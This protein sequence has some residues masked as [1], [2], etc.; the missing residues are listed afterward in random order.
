[1]SDDSKRKRGN[2]HRELLDTFEKATTTFKLCPNRIWVVAREKLPQ[3][4][5]QD[6][7]ILA[8][9]NSISN[10][11]EHHHDLCTFDFCEHSQ[12]DFTAVEQR[13]ECE[14]EE[15]NDCVQLRG[16]FSRDILNAAAEAGSS[17]VWSLDGTSIVETPRPYMAISHVW[18]D[19][20]GTGGWAEGEVN[21]CLYNLFQEIARQFQCEGIWWDTI[22][23]PREKSARNKAIRKIQNNYQDARIT[24]VHD[25]FLRNWEWVNAEGACF[26]IL[27]SPWFSRG[28]TALELAN[29][30][31]VKVVFKGPC[32]PLIKDLDEQILA[33]DDTCSGPHK[34]ATDIIR[35]LRKGVSDLNGLL[36]VLGARH[37]SWPKDIAII[38]GQ[39]VGVEIASQSGKQDIWQQDIYISILRKL[40]KVSPQHLF[41]NSATM[42]RV[43][44]CPNSLFDMPIFDSSVMAESEE[45]L[46]ITED[47]DLV[48]K[49]KCIPVNRSHMEKCVWNGIHPLIRKRLEH[50]LEDEDECVLLT[51][52]VS[53]SEIG[54]VDRAL[55]VKKLGKGSYGYVGAL[56]FHPGLTETEGR[57]EEV[58]LLADIRGRE[59]NPDSNARVTKSR[60]YSDWGIPAL[61][62]AALNGDENRVEN[63]V[64]TASPSLHELASKRIALNYA[65]WRGH[66]DVFHELA[67]SLVEKAED[68]DVQDKLGQRP[69]HLAA[70][71][72]DE[73]AVSYLLH[74]GARVEAKAED[75]EEQTALHRAAWGG[76]TPVVQLL[77]NAGSHVNTKDKFENIALHTAA[78]KGFESVATLLIENGADVDAK[79]WNHLTPLHYAVI[80]RHEAVVKLL[81]DSGAN[82]EAKDKKF[83]WTALH[84]AALTEHEAVVRLLLDNGADIEARD[85]EFGWTALHLAAVNGHKAVVEL[86][87]MRNVKINL[88]DEKDR[89]MLQIAI[90]NG[91]EEVVKLLANKDVKDNLKDEKRRWTAL[92]CA[93]MSGPSA[94]FKPLVDKVDVNFKDNGQTALQL[95]AEN[96]YKA[97]VKKLLVNM[98]YE[99]NAKD[100]DGR[101]ALRLAAE[102]GHVA[103][104]KLL[105]DKGVDADSEHNGKT[106]LHLAVANGHQAVVKLL[107]E[108]GV[109]INSTRW[110]DSAHSHYG[111]TALHWAAEGGYVAMVKLLVENGADINTKLSAQN[112]T[113]LHL[114]A[115]NGYVAVTK[116]LVENGA[117]IE[118]KRADYSQ[119]PLHLAV[120]KG[121]VAVIKQLIKYGA[122]VNVEQEYGQTALHSAAANGDVAIIELLAK[123]GADIDS[124][125]NDCKGY[126]G[127]YGDGYQP[128]Y[129]NYRGQTALHLAVANGHEA[130]VKLLVENGADINS[131]EWGCNRNS[132]HGQAAL[133][134]AAKGGHLVMV[135]LLVENGA[136]IDLENS[137]RGIEDGDGGDKDYGGRTAL[138]MAAANGH[139]A[140]VS[141][142]LKYGA[143]TRL[144][145]SY[146]GRVDYD[147]DSYIDGYGEACD[148]YG[149]DNNEYYSGRTALQLAV[150]NG[151]ES[152]ADLL[153]SHRTT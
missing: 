131:M 108:N 77:L 1:M 16:L 72:G 36:R 40:G 143:N 86:L 148:D 54:L 113:P 82:V 14:E 29:S 89:A 28:W 50:H 47:L 105:V 107:V 63:L 118:A 57:I 43:S 98:R 31:K 87:A 56:Y 53:T 130:V 51:E 65:I 117:D 75:G 145:E 5:P 42:S 94:V 39:L 88:E 64:Q 48:G 46:S 104:V 92:H 49:W 147:S 52:Y 128:F 106:P 129:G 11:E 136:E 69:L 124:T 10:D 138:H 33:R 66:H 114:A 24:L 127:E 58:R 140:V 103:V 38:S 84:L 76:S 83:G 137:Y 62:S 91:Y 21:I 61:P 122:N 121:H 144:E 19:G 26:A 109:D 93:V 4:L 139:G 71:R 41:H 152:V 115:V 70:E 2:S 25:C 150:A 149:H 30:R 135:K 79:G 111:Q 134:W 100:D 59:S 68:L 96:G 125:S 45:T 120:A 32:G 23:I 6:S 74:N 60:K 80:N 141:L 13:H 133:H 132:H 142:L 9:G 101:T 81:L 55:L 37:T 99:A 73:I 15:K 126:H 151:H 112:Q 35:T 67:K 102:N 146:R 78:E 34:A 44:W 119:T 153:A 12:R 90:V 3:L 27:M 17:T 22:C 123:A 110:L 18:S 7:S 95:A 20:T 97:V 85:N 8:D 116:L